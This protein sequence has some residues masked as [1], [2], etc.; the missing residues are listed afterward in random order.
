MARLHGKLH[1]QPDADDS[2][3]KT[4]SLCIGSGGDREELSDRNEIEAA[5]MKGMKLRGCQ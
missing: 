3:V 4:K 2:L 5:D 1:A